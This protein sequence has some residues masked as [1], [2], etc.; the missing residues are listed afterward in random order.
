MATAHLGHCVAGLAPGKTLL[1]WP[2]IYALI[3]VFTK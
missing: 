3:I 1:F 2:I